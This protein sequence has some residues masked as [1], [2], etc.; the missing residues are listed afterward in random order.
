MSNKPASLGDSKVQYKRVQ[1][2]EALPESRAGIVAKFERILDS[3][4]VQKVVVELGHPIKV[5]RLVK[6]GDIGDVPEIQDDDWM[7]AI[8]N[9]EL[10]EFQSNLKNPFAYLFQAFHLLSQKRLRPRIILIH[11]IKEL[12][13]WLGLDSFIDVRELYGV[14]VKAHPDVPDFSGILVAADADEPDGV[15]FSIRLSFDIE[16]EKKNEANRGEGSQE[17]NRGQGNGRAPREVGKPS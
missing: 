8:R 9:G 15:S 3:G 4:G 12:K 6:V 10:E 1:E 13:V 2:T 11:D 7:N 16:K 5:E 17:R 14:E